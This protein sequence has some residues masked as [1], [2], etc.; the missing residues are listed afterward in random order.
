M[1][2][3]TKD[4]VAKLTEDSTSQVSAAGHQMRDDSGARTGGDKAHFEKAPDWA[5]KETDSGIPFF[6]EGKGPSGN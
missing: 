1:G 6:P 4:W 2:K 5:P 3:I